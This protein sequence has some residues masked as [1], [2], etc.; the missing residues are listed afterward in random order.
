MK[1]ISYEY[2]YEVDHGTEEEPRTETIRQRMSIECAEADFAAAY[3]AARRE[4]VGEITVE[5]V[6]DPVQGPTQLDRVEAQTMYT[7]MMTDTLIEEGDD[8]V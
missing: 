1:K 7:A 5:D 4:A 2:V 6:P 8:D 3:A